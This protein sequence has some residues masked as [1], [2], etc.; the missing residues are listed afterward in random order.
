MNTEIVAIQRIRTPAGAAQLRALLEEHVARTNS[1]KA[2]GILDDFE[3]ASA[4][5]WQLVPP[6]EASTPQAN[7]KAQEGSKSEAPE[8][9]TTASK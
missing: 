8:K 2:K 9:I 5:F 3:S 1:S 4:K 7:P 6:S